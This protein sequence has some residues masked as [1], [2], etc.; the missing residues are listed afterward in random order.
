M[1]KLAFVAAALSA[2]A[3]TRT[4]SSDI[5]TSG[6]YASIGANAN[7]DGTT[8]VSAQLLLGDPS[9]LNFVDLT[10]DD[11]LIASFEGQDKVMTES[12]LLNIVT[13]TTSFQSDE[14]DDEFIVDF[15]RSVD[16]GAP[17][18]IITLP[19]P[20]EI[21]APAASSSR[22]QA[23]TLTWSPS[24]PDDT[25]RWS[26]SGDCIELAGATISGDTGTLGLPS[27]TIVKRAGANVP[28][29]CTV[30][31]QLHRTRVGLVDTHFGRGGTATGEQTRQ[32]TFTTTP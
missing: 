6:I 22:A 11:R 30:V 4:E 1:Q 32:V 15:Q 23:M 31:L 5:L 18:S 10:G 19:P 27:G 9:N 17:S 28:D 29:S 13:H 14:A 26:L 12:I 8:T 21:A 24:S 2:A 3:C 7:G 20:F 25:M 16:P